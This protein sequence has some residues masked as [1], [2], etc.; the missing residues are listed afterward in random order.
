MPI[1]LLS[2]VSIVDTP[3]TNAILREHEQLTKE[4]IPQADIVLFITSVDRPFTESERQFMEQ[5]RDWGKKVVILINKIDILQDEDELEQVSAF[6]KEN[7]QALLNTVPET[8][9]VSA[10]W[11]C[12]PKMENL[13]YRESSGFASLEN[14]IK[15]TLDQKSQIR[16][17]FLNPL[18]SA[19]ISSRRSPGAQL[20]RESLRKILAYC[21]TLPTSW[22]S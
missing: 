1:D 13:I 8:F 22:Q 17:K 5:I 3:G 2:E 16:L 6:V 11:P 18:V 4:F 10:R 21:K 9:A 19:L 7:A 15:I 20:K 14:F 12:G